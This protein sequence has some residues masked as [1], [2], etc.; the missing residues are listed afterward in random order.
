MINQT[1]FDRGNSLKSVICIK[2]FTNVPLFLFARVYAVSDCRK[3]RILQQLQ[4][5]SKDLYSLYSLAVLQFVKRFVASSLLHM[6][7]RCETTEATL[8][9]HL[10]G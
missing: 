5:L 8:S 3:R 2:H 9:C 7:G 4:F 6:S 1:P 10:S